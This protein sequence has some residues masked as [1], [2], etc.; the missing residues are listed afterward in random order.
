M[1]KNF[2]PTFVSKFKPELLWNFFDQILTIPRSSGEEEQIRN[3][4]ISVAKKQGLQHKIDSVG[5]LVVKK[6]ATSGHEDRP[7]VV[8][9]A[10][11][12]M[13][14]VPEPGKHDWELPIIP[15]YGETKN[16]L[17]ADGTTLG[18]DNGIGIAAML[19]I[20]V[21]DFNHG[22]LEFLF[23]VDEETGLTGVMELDPDLISGNIVF[24]LDTEDIGETYV[25]CAGGANLNLE[26]TFN[27][28]QYSPQNMAGL[29]ISLSGF[30]G[31]HSGIDI[32][33]PK[34]NA[35][36]ILSGLISKA[37]EKFDLGLISFSGGSAHNAIP[38]SAEADLT[39][40]AGLLND[41]KELLNLL[42]A[43]TKKKMSG[44]DMGSKITLK[45]IPAA[46]YYITY[47]LDLI[48][49]INLLPHGVIANDEEHDIV[50]TSCNVAIAN[51][52]YPRNNMVQPEI[53]I[54]CRSMEKSG[55][56]SLVK[57]IQILA[58]TAKFDM[59]K[60][61][62]YPPWP[63]NYNSPLIQLARDTWP[64][65][66]KFKIKT[67]H[68]GLECGI[69]LDK[70]PGLEAL[71]IGPTIKHPHSL[72]ELVKIDTVALFWEHLL[73]LLNCVK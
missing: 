9:Q 58:E 41:F 49:F 53:L 14:R 29:Q 55:L 2:K 26:S 13:V 64:G 21:G 27:C 45:K 68:A 24:N 6:T 30:S 50:L 28:T 46:S 11:V 25:G 42:F 15:V 59:N 72:N 36:K 61:G 69:L 1:L 66:E 48:N 38:L 18:A 52:G 4:I 65:K 19:A 5:N 20:M 17:T 44:A 73:N 47:G 23:T 56:N 51:T 70:K 71:S 32:H 16:I 3:F 7:T 57:E 60:E 31:G 67:V 62:S 12:D 8:L 34:T 22:P 39:I 40:E 35:V 37:A 10:H 63:P 54:S 43:E 33:L